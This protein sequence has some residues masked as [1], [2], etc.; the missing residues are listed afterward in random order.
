MLASTSAFAVDVPQGPGPIPLAGD[1]NAGGVILAAWDEVRGIS[2]TQ[3]LNLRMDQIQVGQ[4]TPNDGL[5]LDFGIVNLSA[6]GGN[7]SGVIYNVEAGDYFGDNPSLWQVSFTG[8]LD[9]QTVGGS[10]GDGTANALGN[11]NTFQR[12]VNGACGTTVPCVATT[13]SDPQYAGGLSHGHT[14]GGGNLPFDTTGAIG[15]ALSFWTLTSTSDLGGDPATLTRYENANGIGQWLLGTDG[16]LTYS[17]ASSPVPL[18]AAVWLLISGLGGL[19]II[20]RRKNKAV[21]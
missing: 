12:F 18:P 19:G 10:N 16:H 2:V 15:S 20:G 8:G 11:L 21:A 14:G 5:V 6:F 7:T 17:I 3:Y 9:Q 1:S 13:A 4:L